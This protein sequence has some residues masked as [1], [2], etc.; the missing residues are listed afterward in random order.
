MA[1]QPQKRIFFHVGLGKTGTTF[2][3]YRAFPKFKGVKYIQRTQFSKAVQ[4]IKSTEFSKYLISYECDQQLEKIVSGFSESFP[5][6]TP[7]IVLRRHDSWIASQYRRFVK[8]G[9]A[10]PFNEFIDIDHDKGFFKIKDLTFYHQ[11]GILEKYFSNK[12]LLLFYDDLKKD[13]ETF[14]KKLADVMD[15]RIN[16]DSINFNKKHS[17]YNEKQLKVIYQLSQ[18]CNLIKRRRFKNNIL[19]LFWRLYL[20]IIRYG[21]LYAALL[22]PNKSISEQPLIDKNYLESV[23]SYFDEDW[24]K[25]IDCARDNK[26]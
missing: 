25:C 8:N 6:T 19:N 24:Q 7:I 18:K 9:H 13:P 10:I 3:Q 21:T 1:N 22:I 4:I 23:K 15:A 17:S 16:L 2:L 14:I 20:S 11:I 12:P 26:I 5:H